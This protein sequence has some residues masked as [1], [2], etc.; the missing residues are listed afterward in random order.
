MADTKLDI[1]INAAVNGVDQIKSLSKEITD[2]NSNVAQT[3]QASSVAGSFFDTL[4]QAAREL[5]ASLTGSNEATNEQTEASNN[6]ASALSPLVGLMNQSVNSANTKSA[7]FE[8]LGNVLSK[9]KSQILLATTVLAGYLAIE[10]TIASAEKAKEFNELSDKL[11][12]TAL[13]TGITSTKLKE[14]EKELVKTGLTNIQAK[15]QLKAF[16]E[17]QLDSSDAVDNFSDSILEFSKNIEKEFDT[18]KELEEY[19]KNLEI[20]QGKS[21]ALTQEYEKAIL[22]FNRASLSVFD[23]VEQ[24]QERINAV[25]AQL[26]TN[27]GQ[28][29]LPMKKAIDESYK[30]SLDIIANFLVEVNKVVDEFD[31]SGEFAQILG[32]M[33]KESSVILQGVSDVLLGVIRSVGSARNEFVTMAKTINRAIGEIK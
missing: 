31:K 4:A 3:A 19:Y 29:F 13:A 17:A 15:E 5:S 33:F 7:S 16:I 6:S 20:T 23:T 32:S 10:G 28:T 26:V 2:V 22:D 8:I 27:I 12:E 11:N 1:L 9:Y 18:L 30:S 25:Q 24:K 14:Y 21:V